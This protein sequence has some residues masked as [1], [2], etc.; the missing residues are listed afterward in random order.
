[1]DQIVVGVLALEPAPAAPGADRIPARAQPTRR[2]VGAFDEIDPLDGR[3]PETPA[4][5]VGDDEQCDGMAAGDK[6]LGNQPGTQPRA[7]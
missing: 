7:A 3:A 2:E 5:G 4:L 1:M 6:A